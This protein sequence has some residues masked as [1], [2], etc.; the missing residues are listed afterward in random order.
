MKCWKCKNQDYNPSHRNKVE[1]VISNIFPIRPYRCD[2]CDFRFYGLIS[3]LFNRSRAISTGIMGLLLAL[4]VVSAL[5]SFDEEEPTPK[6]EVTQN[7]ES[8][9]VSGSDGGIAT[10]VSKPE[11]ENGAA[12]ASTNATD[13]TS[14]EIGL[15]DETPAIEED[16]SGHSDF[17]KTQLARNRSISAGE[18]PPTVVS[19]KTEAPAVKASPKAEAPRVAAISG[20]QITAV[21]SQLEGKVFRLE[22]ETNKPVSVKKQWLDER[23]PK[24]VV[25]LKGAWSLKRG[26]SAKI[27]VGDSLVKRVRLGSHPNY[28]TIVL[29]LSMEKPGKTTVEPGEKGIVITISKP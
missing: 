7:T 13:N 9:E 5:V 20:G 15:E 24:L 8:A 18:E 11:V 22:I 16:L 29:D 25:N 4:F 17:V 28:F 10:P 2:S 23:G 6:T 19:K 27:P 14:E 26:L 12:A 3:P 21:S 1:K